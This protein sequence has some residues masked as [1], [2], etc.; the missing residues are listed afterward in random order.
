[1]HIEKL[2][3]IQTE[4]VEVQTM[5]VRSQECGYLRVIGET[6]TV[7]CAIMHSHHDSSGYSILLHRAISY[8]LTLIRIRRS[9]CRLLVEL[10]D[11]LVV[12][13]PEKAQSVLKTLSQGS[14]EEENQLYLLA[15]ILELLAHC[16]HVQQMQ[17]P[18]SLEQ[19]AAAILQSDPASPPSVK[20]LA[21]MCG[22]STTTLTR[23][24]R[25]TF[26]TTVRGYLRDLRLEMARDL[27]KNQGFS[28]TEVALS[29]GY[30][31]LPSFSREFHARFGS[32]PVY[33]RRN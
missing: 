22:T 15:K 19:R 17:L 14:P 20:V 24:F 7:N 27:L 6:D 11:V 8:K 1:M 4:E 12:P 18:I 5:I 13:C 9:L 16:L 31:S 3:F 33:F 23:R 30:G 29:V 10:P 26:G 28:V 32:P 2:G 21:A 25:T